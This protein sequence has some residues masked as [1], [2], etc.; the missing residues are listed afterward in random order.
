M[1]NIQSLQD[2]FKEIFIIW[3]N[4]EE[5]KESLNN[6]FGRRKMVHLKWKRYKKTGNVYI[7]TKNDIDNKWWIKRRYPDIHLIRTGNKMEDNK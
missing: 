6:I 5:L 4:W 7:V 3:E 1:K 2:L